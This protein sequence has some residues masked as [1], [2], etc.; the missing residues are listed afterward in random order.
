[1]SQGVG[2]VLARAVGLAE[3]PFAFERLLVALDLAVDLRSVRRDEQ[4]PDAVAGE[5]FL[6]DLSRLQR[7]PLEP[8]CA[9]GGSAAVPRRAE[10]AL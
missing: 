8:R 5:R 6:D 7:R 2:A 1:V 10:S 9:S 3:R 4:V